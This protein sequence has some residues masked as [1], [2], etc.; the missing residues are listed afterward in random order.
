MP[1]QL[2]VYCNTPFP[3]T[4]Q[5]NHH[6]LKKRRCR[7]QKE[8]AL[9]KLLPHSVP[10]TYHATESQSPPAYESELPDIG[11][12]KFFPAN[13]LPLFYPPDFPNDGPQTRQQGT[14]VE[15]EPDEEVG[16]EPFAVDQDVGKAFGMGT[17]S[18]QDIREAQLR[19]G[20][21]VYGPFLDEEEWGLAKWLIQNVGQN[22]TEAF[23]KLPIIQNR[24]GP[25]YTNKDKFLDAINA[26]PGG[27]EWCSKPVTVKGD[28]MDD[29]GQ[30]LT[31][32][33]ELWMRDPVE[34]VAEL[35]GNPMFKDVMRYA[36]ERHYDDRNGSKGKHID[37]MWTARWWWEVQA[38]SN[39]PP[40]PLHTADFT[41]LSNDT[42]IEN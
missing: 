14:T 19:E 9:Q 17:T 36:P 40:P 10:S 24:V 12:S 20:E 13:D 16:I 25:E 4:G 15:D 30:L 11:P 37:E 26:L 31:E 35:M 18:F 32:E 21:D 38:V 39:T 1:S 29:N 7:K 33:L 5:L 41:V 22:A 8:D 34:C 2:C 42:I 27:V 23:L 3:T 6:Q 28:R